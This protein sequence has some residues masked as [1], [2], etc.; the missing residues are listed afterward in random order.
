MIEN[1]IF[2]ELDVLHKEIAEAN[3]TLNEKKDRYKKLMK[4]RINNMCGT[5]V[6]KCAAYYKRNN[7]GVIFLINIKNVRPTEGDKSFAVEADRVEV[8]RTNGVSYFNDSSKK[9]VTSIKMECIE[10]FR[11]IPR[12]EIFIEIGKQL[13][14]YYEQH[15]E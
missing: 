10:N 8:S 13:D 1:N 2:E 15:F 11:E 14:K 12:D 5:L 3:R 9:S 6:G 4:D 7:S